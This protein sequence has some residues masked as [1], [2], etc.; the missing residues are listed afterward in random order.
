MIAAGDRVRVKPG[1]ND[2]RLVGEHPPTGIVRSVSDDEHGPH[3]EIHLDDGAVLWS[4]SP[5][6]WTVLPSDSEEP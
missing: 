2:A 5:D 6:D 4:R 3:A 1:T